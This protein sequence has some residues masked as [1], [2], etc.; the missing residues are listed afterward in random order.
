LKK[1]IVHTDGGCSGNPGPGGWAALLKYG[2]HTKELSGGEPVTTNNRMELQAAIGALTAL[3]EPCDIEIFT[4]SSYL[5]GGMT[6]WL[7]SWKARGWRTLDKKPVKN[8]D[9]WRELDRLTGPHRLTWRW[10]KGHAGHA[11]NERCD[12]LATEE[13]AKIRARFTREQIAALRADF[14]ASRL[15]QAQQGVLL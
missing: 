3:T 2:D 11:E 7:R 10:V 13:I 1:L 8:E 12:Q 14:E 15:P 4:D 9:L 6:A 5:K